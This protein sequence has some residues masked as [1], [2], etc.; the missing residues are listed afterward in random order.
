MLSTDSK[1]R[2]KVVVIE[3][4]WLLQETIGAMLS[5]LD[6]VEVVG[7]AADERSAIELLQSQRPDLAIVDLQLQTGSGFGVLRAISLNPEY[8]GR[9][10]TVVFSHHNQPEVR[11]RCFT[12]G[13][14]RFFDKAT[15]MGELISYV[16]QAIPS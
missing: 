11:K 12:L 6:R 16:R 13:V 7:G 15:E 14:D 3:D 9:P 10:R 8:F 2:L 5:E 1:L 4:S